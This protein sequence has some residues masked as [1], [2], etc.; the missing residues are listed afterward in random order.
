MWYEANTDNPIAF[1]H[2]STYNAIVGILNFFKNVYIVRK[3]GEE[4]RS[5]RVPLIFE[6]KDVYARHQNTPDRK[7]ERDINEVLPAM[8]LGLTAPPI[9]MRDSG[10]TG[11]PKLQDCFSQTPGQVSTLYAGRPFTIDFDLTLRAKEMHELYNMY[12]VIMSRLWRGPTTISVL[13]TMLKIKRDIMLQNLNIRWGEYETVFEKG[14]NSRPVEIVISFTAGPIFF[15]PPIINGQDGI[16]KHIEI[17]YKNM[18]DPNV[19]DPVSFVVNNWDVDP[20]SAASDEPHDQIL[21]QTL[22]GET[23]EIFRESMNQ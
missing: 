14:G 9:P 15:Y 11:D 13:D 4:Y 1:Y 16:I 5:H 7:L 19:E 3:K 18:C 20:D 17:D 12:E 22:A 6:G 8:S 21:T 2:K 10:T 23:T